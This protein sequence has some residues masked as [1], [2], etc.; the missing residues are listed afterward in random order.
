MLQWTAPELVL[1]CHLTFSLWRLHGLPLAM[2][3]PLATVHG[4]FGAHLHCLASCIMHASFHYTPNSL[5]IADA[6]R[7]TLD[8]TG[9]VFHWQCFVLSWFTAGLL[10]RPGS[11]SF[12]R[13]SVSKTYDACEKHAYG[14]L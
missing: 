13:A 1:S 3:A 2:P 7:W 10:L 11:L 14:L 12:L 8:C 6:L 4:S 5:Q 9:A